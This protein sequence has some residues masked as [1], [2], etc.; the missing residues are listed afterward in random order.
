MVPVTFFKFHFRRKEDCAG[1][2]ARVSSDEEQERT[3]DVAL[4]Q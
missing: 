3:A 4:E 1:G 2:G